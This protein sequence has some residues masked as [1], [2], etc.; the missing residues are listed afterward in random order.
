VQTGNN[1]TSNDYTNKTTT[2]TNNTNNTNNTNTNNNN[3]NNNN[4]NTNI[5]TTTIYKWIIQ[6][7]S[8]LKPNRC[9][10]EPWRNF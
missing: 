3:N 2:T 7:T 5:Y 6:Y 1:T 9:S 4:N 8:N 10:T